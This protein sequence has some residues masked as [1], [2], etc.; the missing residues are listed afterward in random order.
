MRVFS[1]H[2]VAFLALALLSCT[3]GEQQL[4]R[5]E[6][7]ASAGDNAA[8]KSELSP[9]DAT[10][11]YW[12][13][14][15]HV[16]V[17]VGDVSYDFIGSNSVPAASAKFTGSAPAALGTYVMLS[18][19][20]G[21]ATNSGGTIST[22]LPYIQISRAGS[23]LAGTLVLAGQSNTSSVTC[24][25]VCSGFRF[26]LSTEEDISQVR[27]R[28]LN[29]EKIAGNFTFSFSGANPVASAGT[30]EE[31]VLTPSEGTYFAKDQWYYIAILPTNFTNGIC[32]TA[33]SASRGAGTF[34]VSDNSKTN[35]LRARFKSKTGLDEDMTWPSSTG[36]VDPGTIEDLAFEDL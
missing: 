36:T 24:N 23:F 8:V 34:T 15:E 14:G 13:V 31:V 3:K 7:S 10:K 28:G 32:V 26:K 9:G 18:P 21:S 25:H 11:V 30:Q 5:H 29:G 35:F 22:T 20:N 16:N 27:L 12:S 4:I 17:F 1:V 6:I 19:Y 2:S 33:L